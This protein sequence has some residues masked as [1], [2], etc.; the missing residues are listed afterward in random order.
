M[1]M[2]N[3]DDREPPRKGASAH[4]RTARVGCG[5]GGCG[6]GRQL[7]RGCCEPWPLY[8]TRT[9]RQRDKERNRS[10]SDSSL[11]WKRQATHVMSDD[12][13]QRH[14]SVCARLGAEPRSS[15]GGNHATRRRRRRRR[16]WWWRREGPALSGSCWGFGCV[17]ISGRDVSGH[18]RAH[19]SPCRAGV[20]K[21]TLVQWLCQSESEHQDNVLENTSWTV[22][23][24]VAVMVRSCRC[25]GASKPV[26]TFRVVHAARR[27]IRRPRRSSR[28]CLGRLWPASA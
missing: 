8:T 13:T 12:A 24:E 17:V 23:C 16:W 15:Q 28:S 7:E 22:G 25:A 14:H 11:P 26:F 4:A 6:S 21:S 5:G 2:M 10:E 19:L 20:G 3:D 9:E 1:M 27:C 18:P